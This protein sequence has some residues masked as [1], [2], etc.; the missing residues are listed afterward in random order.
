MDEFDFTVYCTD[1]ECA[2][3]PAKYKIAAEWSAG[4]TTE[5]KTFGFADDVCLERVY[6]SA[7]ERSRQIR[8]SEGERT[9]RLR[10]LLLDTCLHDYELQPARE[11]E[12]KL[13][14]SD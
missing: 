1:A 10:V 7:Q 3:R 11:W 8:L 4:G 14:Q 9:G 2:D 13:A 12:Q 6:R 5:L